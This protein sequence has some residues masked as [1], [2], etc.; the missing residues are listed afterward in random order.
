MGK[1][2]TG[3]RLDI[4][5]LRGSTFTA[6]VFIPRSPVQHDNTVPYGTV[7]GAGDIPP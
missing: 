1:M 4:H 2:G 5:E 7:K 6:L 3:Q